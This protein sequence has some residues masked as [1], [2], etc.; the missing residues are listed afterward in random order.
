MATVRQ[1]RVACAPGFRLRG[2]NLPASCANTL[3]IV[4]YHRAQRIVA[5]M[6]KCLRRKIITGMKWWFGGSAFV[7]VSRR[8]FFIAKRVSSP[9]IVPTCAMRERAARRCYPG[10][11]FIYAYLFNHTMTALMACNRYTYS[12]SELVTFL[13]TLRR[14][15]KRCGTPSNR[16]KA[17]FVPSQSKR[18]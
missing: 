18:R 10:L 5:K 16:R 8:V 2:L 9:R 3:A 14:G 4:G 11:T 7:H 6:P 13:L 17:P 15:I 1:L 12:T